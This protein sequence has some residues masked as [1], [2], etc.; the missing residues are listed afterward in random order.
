[1]FLST[2]ITDFENFV[3]YDIDF[4]IGLIK[5]DENLTAE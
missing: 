5:S 2:M 3:L 4:F 1:M